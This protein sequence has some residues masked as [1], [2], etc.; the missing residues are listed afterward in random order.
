MKTKAK[1]KIMQ[2]LSTHVKGKFFTCVHSSRNTVSEYCAKLVSES[3]RYITIA[4]MNTGHHIKM[5][6]DALVAVNCG[7]FAYQR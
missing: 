7:Q 4:D 2:N 5:S 1:T 3:P 6:K